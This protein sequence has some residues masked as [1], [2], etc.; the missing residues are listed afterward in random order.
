MDEMDE[1][2]LRRMDRKKAV[3][4]RPVRSRPRLECC[5]QTAFFIKNVVCTQHFLIFAA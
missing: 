5:L 2:D 4:N 1:S 3:P